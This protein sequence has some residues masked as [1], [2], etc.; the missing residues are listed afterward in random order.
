ME[1]AQMVTT[2]AVAIVTS[3]AAIIHASMVNA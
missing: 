3:M 2:P 1:L